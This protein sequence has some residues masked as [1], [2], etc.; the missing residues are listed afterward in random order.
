MIYGISGHKQ[1]GKDTVGS[2]IQYL[3]DNEQVQDKYKITYK[4]FCKSPYIKR[5]EWQIKKFADKL[6][7]IL[8]ILTGIPVK[9]MEKEEFKNKLLGEEWKVWTY[10]VNTF[11]DN[12]KYSIL[13]NT[14]KE[15]EQYII[16][17]GWV[18]PHPNITI[19]E[20]HLTIREALQ[21]IGTNLFRD[22]FHTNCWV[23]A[24]M[25]EYKD[26]QWLITDVRFPNE[27]QSIVNRGG[28][29]IRVNRFT[30]NNDLHESETAL[31][32]YNDWHYIL[33]NNG[34]IEELIE[35]VKQILIKEKL[36]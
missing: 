4:E 2:I 28:K 16:S 6:K 10:I 27:V 12:W 15:V 26:Q 32:N 30:K 20:N 24:L 31:D 23:N 21:Y 25:N 1:A 33:D 19:K 35:Q 29:M 11:E 17:K 36:I 22:K 14:K 18:L 5:S 3:V 8:S 7:Q 9:D 34:T 13:R